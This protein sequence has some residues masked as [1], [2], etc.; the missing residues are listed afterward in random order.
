[1]LGGCYYVTSMFSIP[2]FMIPESFKVQGATAQNMPCH[3]KVFFQAGILFLSGY[4]SII[5]STILQH[6]RAT[7]RKMT[8]SYQVKSYRFVMSPHAFHLPEQGEKRRERSRCVDQQLPQ[9]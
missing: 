5:V 7:Q 1:M 2:G 4:S 9:L 8:L 3:L 6:E